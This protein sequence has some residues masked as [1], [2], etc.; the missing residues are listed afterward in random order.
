MAFKHNPQMEEVLFKNP[1]YGL[2]LFDSCRENAAK[3]K[4]LPAWI[5]DGTGIKAEVHVKMKSVFCDSRLQVLRAFMDLGKA[6]D[7]EVAEYLSIRINCIT[8]RRKELQKTGV[9][10]SAGEKVIGPFG[11]P[12]TVWYVDYEK[13]KGVLFEVL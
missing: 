4:S 6:T 11:Q 1:T 3:C 5:W 9:I 7:N 13:L 12:N 10:F 2:P 8:G